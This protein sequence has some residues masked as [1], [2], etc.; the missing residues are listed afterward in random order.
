MRPRGRVCPR[1]H[2]SAVSSALS[3]EISEV[4]KRTA[5][6]LREI[7]DGC[8]RCGQSSEVWLAVGLADGKNG[9]PPW[10]VVNGGFSSIP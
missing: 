2:I 7:G 1:G 5:A 4:S 8:I 3:C 9:V 10:R 6:I